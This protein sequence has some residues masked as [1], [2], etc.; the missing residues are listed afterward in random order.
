ME[1]LIWTL[2]AYGTCNIL[3]FGSN[4]EWWRNL[5]SKF[6]TGGYSIHKLFSCM[7]CLPTWVGFTMSYLIHKYTTLNTPSMMY[8]IESLWLSILVDGVLT[9]GCVWLIHTFQEAMERHGSK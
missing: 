9:S 1:L 4:F 3:I 8:G 5:L 6:G 2:T 7:M